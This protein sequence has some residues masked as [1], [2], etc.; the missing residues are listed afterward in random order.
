MASPFNIYLRG[1][2]GLL[3]A[4]VGGQAPAAFEDAIRV[5]LDANRFLI[6]Q[7]QEVLSMAT[8]AY[9]TLGT[10]LDAA[11]LG[12]VPDSEIWF[13]HRFVCKQTVVLAA[14]EFH[15]FQPTIFGRSTAGTNVTQG[16]ANNPRISTATD[17]PMVVAQEAFVALPGDSLGVEATTVTTAGTFTINMFAAFVRFPT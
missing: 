5:S 1:L 3:D 7:K 11:G 8:A 6:A 12:V 14:G 2:L 16:L 13:V 4:K 9:N 15:C 10:K 17:R